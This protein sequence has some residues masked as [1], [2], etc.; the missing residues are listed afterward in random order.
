MTTH[1]R[2]LTA[3]DLLKIPDRGQRYELLDGDL[4]EMSPTNHTHARLMTKVASAL[5][6]YVEAHDLGEVLSGDPGIILRRNPDRVRAPDVCFIARNRVPPESS[7]YGFIEVV[8]DLVIEIV[9]PND[10]PTEVQAKIEEWLRAGARLVWAAYPDTR[11]IVAHRGVHS[12][13]VYTESDIL[14]GDPVLP[15]FTYPVAD[16]FS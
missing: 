11:S 14:D 5:H 1:K 15:V 12:H 4:V 3:E 10:T 16:L 7:P 6:L 8:P 2:A 9:S 13:R